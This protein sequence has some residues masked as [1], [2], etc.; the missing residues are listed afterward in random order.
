KS[1]SFGWPGSKVNISGVIPDRNLDPGKNV[2]TSEA[3]QQIVELLN[4]SPAT[5]PQLVTWY[6]EDLVT[7]SHTYGPHSPLVDDSL[8][9]ID[10]AIESLM[11]KLRSLSLHNTT[12]III[13]SDHGV[14]K[15]SPELT[16]PLPES[17]ITDSVRHMQGTTTATITW[18][19]HSH[20]DSSQQT[21]YVN[22]LQC[23]HSHLKVFTKASA[24]QQ[25]RF[26]NN[27]RAGD[28][29]VTTTKP[30]M[31]KPKSGFSLG[32]SGYDAHEE[33]MK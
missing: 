26:L 12:N 32:S 11:V 7:V 20:N 29:Y 15:T 10:A 27:P 17:S 13:V 18:T 33:N 8:K 30:W 21:Q 1:V 16:V 3:V 4:Q 25:F 22:G 9:V 31:F 24:P 19:T 2:P 23:L 5:R 14:L 6:I 28:V